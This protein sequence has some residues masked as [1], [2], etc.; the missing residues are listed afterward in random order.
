MNR[1]ETGRCGWSGKFDAVRSSC[2]VPWPFGVGPSRVGLERHPVCPA[3]T[4]GDFIPRHSSDRV[5]PTILVCRMFSALM[6]PPIRRVEACC[7]VDRGH[8]AIRRPRRGLP[9]GVGGSLCL[10]RQESQALDGLVSSHAKQRSSGGGLFVWNERF[11]AGVDRPR[12]SDRSRI[13]LCAVAPAIMS[14]S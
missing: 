10:S 1:K 6:I 7:R 9:G 11:P 14:D 12:V 4:R 13:R 8:V 5:L 2:P 3:G